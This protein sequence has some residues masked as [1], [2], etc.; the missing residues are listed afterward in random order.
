MSL[1]HGCTTILCVLWASRTAQDDCDGDFVG[2][3]IISSGVDEVPVPS[4]IVGRVPYLVASNYNT[5]PP[6]PFL[7]P[8][9]RGDYR[10]SR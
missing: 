4:S 3:I 8:S 10:A 5:R 9:N 6:R 1:V 7:L 2:E